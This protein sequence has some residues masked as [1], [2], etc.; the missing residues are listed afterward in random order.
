MED[1][2]NSNDYYEVIPNIKYDR[3]KVKIKSKRD[4]ILKQIS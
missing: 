2:K 4:L 3:I 1:L